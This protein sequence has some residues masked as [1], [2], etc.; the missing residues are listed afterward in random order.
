VVKHT[1]PR[2]LVTRPTVSVI[3]PCYN[4]GSYLPACVASVLGQEGVDTD[5]L[6]VDDAS[7]D[8]S[9][10]VARGLVASDPRVHLI[11]HQVN[12]GHIATYNQGLREASGAYVVLLS[13]DDLLAPGCLAR[14]AALLESNTDVGFV[15]GYPPRFVDQPPRARTAV[16][17]WSIWRG[18]EWLRRICQRGSN[19]IFC[20]EVVMRAELMRELTGYDNRLPH[21]ADF[22]LW[23][24]AAARASVGRVN[25][26][27][28]A[29]YRV[30]GQNMHMNKYAGIITD[31]KERR[32]AFEIF[33]EG[34]RGKLP[35][36]RALQQQARHSLACE[37]LLHV[38]QS[39]DGPTL[40]AEQR[41]ELVEFAHETCPQIRGGR[42]WRSCE[43]RAARHESG[44]GPS[45]RRRA[46]AAFDDLRK[47]VRWHRWYRY[48]I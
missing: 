41:T 35:R 15:Y 12:M 18:D 30:H 1:R 17:S 22:H 44:S 34:D 23:L 5:I 26:C 4:Y 20:P 43:S 8:G 3:I 36:W 11:E 10:A 19:V 39:Y 48:G 25:G 27:D 6:I 2:Q 21:S 16:R 38:R 42:L 24:R 40:T 13:A 45:T 31:I 47:R 28:Q 9:A 32:H 29:F 37:A 33:F 46:T 7:P 14:A